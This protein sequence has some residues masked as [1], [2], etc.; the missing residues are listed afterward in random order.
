MNA[1][2]N[3]YIF[4]NWKNYFENYFIRNVML[5]EQLITVKS[6]AWANPQQ[7]KFRN[8]LF[9]RIPYNLIKIFEIL[10]NS[11]WKKIF[12]IWWVL[13]KLST[14]QYFTT[15]NKNSILLKVNSKYTF[16]ITNKNYVII[17][18]SKLC[19]VITTKNKYQIYTQKTQFHEY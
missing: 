2:L 4:F 15:E 18:L 14:L 19:I 6:I 3:I 5:T 16:S 10:G 9:L 7:S 8:C 11:N 12:C 1:L 17:W 13:M